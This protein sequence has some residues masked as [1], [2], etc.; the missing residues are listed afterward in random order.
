MARSYL[1]SNVE[2]YKKLFPNLC[3]DLP[4]VSNMKVDVGSL[5]LN[6]HAFIVKNVRDGFR[7]RRGGRKEPK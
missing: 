7:K 2:E 3:L 5:K 6:P 1:L 4:P